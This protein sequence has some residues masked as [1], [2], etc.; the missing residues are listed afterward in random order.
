MPSGAFVAQSF[1]N[2]TSLEMP[3]RP[4]PEQ[5]HAE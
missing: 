1:P 3:Y 4:V 2:D 5:S